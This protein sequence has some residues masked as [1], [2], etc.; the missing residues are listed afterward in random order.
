MSLEAVL[1]TF[2]I[3]A[4]KGREV[5]IVDVHGAFLTEDHYEVINMT[6]GGK[7]AKPMVKTAPEVYRK[8]VVIEK[9]KMV[10]YVKLLKALY[11]CLRSALLFYKKLLA[12]LEPR[13]FDLN[14][15]DPCVINNKTKGEKIT[16]T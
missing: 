11:G 15:Y 12:D 8:Y 2:V 14:P 1:I 9:G 6:P 7:L 4:Y 16:I 3:D 5:A 10:L 13:G